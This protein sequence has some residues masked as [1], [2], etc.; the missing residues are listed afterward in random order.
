M[1][2]S[3]ALALALAAMGST[4]LSHAAPVTVSFSALV[5]ATGIDLPAVGSTIRGTVTFGDVPSS[6]EL[7]D[8]SVCSPSI[9]CAGY[10]FDTAPS[11]FSVDLGGTVITSSVVGVGMSVSD[12][13]LGGPLIDHVSLGTKVNGVSY[14]LALQGVSNSFS[15]TNLSDASTFLSQWKPGGPFS[16]FAVFNGPF[17]NRLQAQVTALSVSSVPEPTTVALFALGLGG[18]AMASRRRA[19]PACQAVNKG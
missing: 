2:K 18:L 15:V 16:R 19:S 12:G 14:F 8:P 10:N 6:V 7:P 11:Q 3:I 13:L 5:T 9:A 1:K 17:T 4:Q